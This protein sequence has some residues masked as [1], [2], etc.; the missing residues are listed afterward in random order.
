MAETAKNHSDISDIDWELFSTSIAEIVE[1]PNT[2]PKEYQ[3]LFNA[4][5]SEFKIDAERFLNHYGVIRFDDINNTWQGVHL[6]QTLNI[7]VS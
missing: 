6:T 3:Y 5:V 7:D 2:V 1:F 4:C